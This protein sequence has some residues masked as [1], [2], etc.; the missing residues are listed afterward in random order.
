[1][2]FFLA[3]IGIFSA[4]AFSRFIPHPPNFTSLIALSFYVP[5]ILGLRYLPIL[6]ISFAITD[7]F[8]GYHTGTHWTWGSVVVIGL[9]SQYFNKNINFRFIGALFGASIFFLITNLGVWLSGGLYEF[10]LGGLITC[11]T[12]ALPFFGYTAISTVIF[13]A[14]IE[15]GYGLCKNNIKTLNN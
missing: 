1:M 11:F 5:A 12:L 3:S 4:L 10:T 14:I 13:S 15:A 7:L 6:I 8:I 2:K 9:V